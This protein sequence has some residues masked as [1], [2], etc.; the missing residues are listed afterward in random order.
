MWCDG[1]DVEWIFWDVYDVMRCVVVDECVVVEYFCVGVGV[2][3][4]ECDDVCE[5]GECVG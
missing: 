3:V 4:C 2:C 1:V 5:C